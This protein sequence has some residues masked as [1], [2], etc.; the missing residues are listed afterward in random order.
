MARPARILIAG[1]PHHIVQRGHDRQPV[2]ACDADYA[3]YLDNL[4]E[5]MR[6]RSIGSSNHRFRAEPAARQRGRSRGRS[7][8]YRGIPQ[9]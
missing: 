4:A 2:F 8:R 7:R 3:R 9:V 1:H 5:Q 6:I